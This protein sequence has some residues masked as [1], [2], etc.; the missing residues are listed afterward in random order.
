MI[1]NSFTFSGYIKQTLNKITSS[2]SQYKFTYANLKSLAELLSSLSKL[3]KQ[4][5][6]LDNDYD[7]YED[8]YQNIEITKDNKISNHLI[9]LALVSFHQKKGSVIECTL[10]N[11]EDLQNNPIIKP[12]L[13]FKYSTPKEL[14]DDLFFQLTNNALTDGIHLVNKDTEFFFIHNYQKPLYCLS[15]YVQVKT[16]EVEESNNNVIDD[17]QK[18][19]RNCIQKA[20]C[21]VSTIPLF[22]NSIIY[23]NFY[24]QLVNQM[25]TF[26][27]QKSLNDK[28]NLD[29]LYKSLFTIKDIKN[30]MWIFNLRK[31]YCYIK[32]DIFTLI[33]L[34]LLEK[35]IIVYSQIPSNV[36]MFII[37]LIS[38][39]P[40]EFSQGLL[41]SYSQK[42]MPFKIFHDKYL[43]Y[44]LF[45]LFD[46][47]PL[48]SK[49]NS[50]KNLNFLIGTTNSMVSNSNKLIYSCKIDLDKPEVIYNKKNTSA[51]I[52]T[53]NEVEEKN[54]SIISN[55]ISKNI[56]AEGGIYNNKKYCVEGDWII[57]NANEKNLEENKLIK[58]IINHYF[59]SIIADISYINK[60]IKNK[61]NYKNIDK[62]S[63]P[64]YDKIKNNY[65][66]YMNN[67]TN[68]QMPKLKGMGM[69]ILPK[70]KKEEN[71]LFS[72][73]EIISEPLY[74]IVNSILSFNITN[75]KVFPCSNKYKDL[76]SLISKQNN[77][78]FIIEWMQTKNFKKWYCSYDEILT[79]LSNLNIE[80]INIKIYD[81]D[82]N[83]YTGNL[84]HGKKTGEAKLYFVE[85]DM[86]YMGG[87][88]NDLKDG[89]GNLTSKDNK[90]LYD[91]GWKNDKYNGEGS[92]LSPKL[93]KYSGNFK[94]GLFN[95]KG[96]LITPDNNEYKGNFLKGEKSGEGE[97]KLNTGYVYKGE[98]KNDL[99]HGMGKLYDNKKIIIQEGKFQKG[100][101]VK[102]IK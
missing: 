35:K 16:D 50:N 5:I 8:A 11:R 62:N 66:K 92:L 58:K 26:M 61:N 78:E 49:I 98:F 31:I 32:E 76:E 40:G 54:N 36:S 67:N 44:P 89:K 37:T 70:T 48:L 19:E 24:T 65:D 15:H 75:S 57:S 73:E 102:F 68:V 52:T 95:G 4:I 51:N 72:I 83:L 100:E 88:K 10:P 77:L 22:G 91:G 47:E 99:Y 60:E 86:T 45:S 87:F 43:I 74:N 79:N 59:F 3:D 94:D 97:Y 9:F 20:L 29:I 21:I 23:Q 7:N 46:L 18:N 80:K 90:F 6:D 85:E 41:K 13:N 38:L 63:F 81:F 56:K 17:F 30:S 1:R 71:N 25:D 33:K 34:V 55:F 84:L 64:I 14:L 39:L 2:P 12:L 82:N 93:G 27:E 69:P 42:G 53:V 101:F 28:T 96:Y